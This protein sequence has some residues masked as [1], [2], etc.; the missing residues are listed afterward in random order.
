MFFY[1]LWSFFFC[2]LCLYCF[3]NRANWG[4]LTTVT[5][6]DAKM[7]K[8]WAVRWFK[9]H[10]FN[11]TCLHSLHLS[12]HFLGII[13]AFFSVMCENDQ[14][15]LQSMVF[16]LLCDFIRELFVGHVTC[17]ERAVS[18]MANSYCI[19]LWIYLM[20]HYAVQYFVNLRNLF[21][22]CFSFVNSLW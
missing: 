6:C 19:R 2:V 5:E 17:I 7:V 18:S 3:E 9:N 10:H 4:P 11:F 15:W 13:S 16:Q 8:D 1:F 14:I 20:L 21:L 12:N 22:F